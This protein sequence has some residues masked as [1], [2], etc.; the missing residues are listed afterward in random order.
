[1]PT[2]C[3]IGGTVSVLRALFRDTLFLTLLLVFAGLTV[4]LNGVLQKAPSLVDWPTI[5]SLAGLLVLTKGVELSGYLHRLGERIITAMRTER[6]LAICLVSTSALLST[7]LTN[8]VALFIVVPLTVSLHGLAA[9]PVTRLIVFEALAVNAGSTL[10]PIGNP[11][12]LFLWQISHTAFHEFVGAMLPLTGLLMLPLLG[13]TACAFRGRPVTLHEEMRPPPLQ[14]HLLWLSLGLYLP[15]L[16]LADLHH[17]EAALLLLLIVYLWRYRTVLARVD[18]TLMGVFILMFIDLRLLAQIGPVISLIDRLHPDQ[19]A[20]LY[21]AGVSVS[22]IISNV[23]AAILFAEYSKDWRIIAYAVNVGGFGLALGSLAN[24]I[25]LRMSRDR[26][27][28]LIFHGYSLPFLLLSAT[29]VYLWL[30]EV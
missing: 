18:W 5:A 1:M 27:A 26:R 30:L 29:L 16:A 15:F 7:L 19:P 13:L 20:S 3:K 4:S 14:K 28:W 25:A 23:P 24:I 22:Q 21:L 6:T 12:N 10:T 2:P 8:D 17:A 9:L 11:Q